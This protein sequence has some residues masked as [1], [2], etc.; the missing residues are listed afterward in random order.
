MRRARYRSSAAFVLEPPHAPD[1]AV[2]HLGRV[3]LRFQ[4]AGLDQ[5]VDPR[6]EDVKVGLRR[7]ATPAERRADDPGHLPEVLFRIG[8]NEIVVIRDRRRNEGI[9]VHHP[10]W[11]ILRPQLVP[12]CEIALAFPRGEGTGEVPERA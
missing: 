3:A 12:E 2:A 10:Q 6:M 4:N 7:V 5:L 9:A 11:G 8:E 1:L